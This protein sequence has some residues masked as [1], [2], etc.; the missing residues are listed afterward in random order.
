MKYIFLSL[1]TVILFN[2]APYVNGEDK[3]DREVERV[4]FKSE[5]AGSTWSYTW[6]GRDYIFSFAK[7]GGISKLESWSSVVWI[8]P[9]KNL[10]VLKSGNQKM[11]LH[12]NE[13][14]NSFK[15]VDWDGQ[16]AVGKLLLKGDF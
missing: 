6:R 9:E 12:F 15:T 7:N 1:L 2:F 8:A 16:L 3:F 4:S 10:V 14:S 5:I 13:S 11:Y